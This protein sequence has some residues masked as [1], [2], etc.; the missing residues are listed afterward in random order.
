[1]TGGSVPH[2]SAR[3]TLADGAASAEP[4][5]GAVAV[6]GTFAGGGGVARSVVCPTGSWN[7]GPQWM[8]AADKSQPAKK[9]MRVDIGSLCSRLTKSW[10]RRR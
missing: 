9:R 3:S 5:S 1:M 7:L 2:A 4:P 10:A 6:E 8:H